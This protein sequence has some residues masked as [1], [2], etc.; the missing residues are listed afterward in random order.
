[1]ARSPTRLSVC[2]VVSAPAARLEA[3]LRH[4]REFADQ[5]VLSVD[6]SSTPETLAVAYEYADDVAVVEIDGLPNNAYGWTA[7]RATGDWILVLDDDEVLDSEFQRSLP[8]LLEE[9][10]T[11]FHLPVR[12]IVQDANGNLAWLRE[13]PWYPNHA[14]RLFRNLAGCYRHPAEL[15]GVWEVA[16]EGRT[17]PPEADAILH[18]NLALLD[19]QERLHK[20][21]ERYRRSAKTGVP[22]CEEYYLYED[23]GEGLERVPLVD[24]VAATLV[25][26]GL[27]LPGRNRRPAS[28]PQ[29]VVAV[30]AR[31]LG[32]HAADRSPEPP[33]WS[34]EYV[35]HDTALELGANRGHLVTLSVRNTSDGTW[36]SRG[37]VV[38]RV[39]ISYRWRA[40]DGSLVIPQGDITLLPTAL[41]PGGEAEV[42]AGLWTPAEP[43]GYLLEWEALC[44]RVAWFSDHDVEPLKLMVDVVDH[45]TRPAAHHFVSAPPAPRELVI[46]G[47][48][49]GASNPS[50]VR[51]RLTRKVRRAAA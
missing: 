25:L 29:E 50:S 11:H 21:N 34:A 48:G 28:P 31:Q 38:G 19:R 10:V 20:I 2:A 22:T 8:S 47:E 32:A 37:D 41:P 44:E 33:I 12:W 43:G 40:P 36:R 3:W 35:A 39:V 24:A 23:F 45:G 5:I 42:A 51:E 15:H 6:R 13:F 30:S 14:T 9:R 16:G 26:R 17:L 1:M 46:D 27:P 18:L 4:V 49:A 7:E